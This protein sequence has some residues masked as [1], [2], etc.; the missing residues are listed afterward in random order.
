MLVA[1][2]YGWTAPG[3]VAADGCGCSMC[4][5]DQDGDTDQADFGH[6]QECFGG[7]DGGMTPECADADLNGNGAIEVGD[8]EAFTAC[9]GGADI[10]VASG[11]LDHLF[12]T[13]FMASNGGV[14]ADEDGEHPDWV[15]LHNPCRPAMNLNGYYLTDDPLDLT[16][17]RFPAVTLGKGKFLVVFASDKDRDDPTQPLH[18]NFKLSAESGYLALVAPDGQTIVHAYEPEYSEQLSDV[19]FGLTQSATQLIAQRADAKYRILVF[20]DGLGTSWTAPD[21]V[22][23]SWNNAKTGIG[24][25]SVPPYFDVTVYKANISVSNLAVAES[26]I[27]QPSQQAWVATEQTTTINYFN[28]DSEGHF[29]SNAT[30]PG[31]QIGSGVDHFVVLVTGTIVIPTPGEWSFGVNSDDGFG[32]TLTR[33]NQVYETSYPPPRGPS[34]TIAVFNLVEAGTYQVRLVYYEQGGGAGLEFFAAQG[35]YP[36]F[37]ANAYRLVGDSA[38]GGVAVGV[39]G[40]TIDTDLGALMKNRNASLRI[41]VPFQV[42]DPAAFNY[43]SLRMRYEDGFVAF[44]N[45]VEVARRNAPE[46]LAWN[47]TATSDRSLSDASEPEE[48]NLTSFVGHLRQGANVLAI[49]GLNDTAADGDF[50]ILPELVAGSNT[51]EQQYFANP[52]PGTYNV[53]GSIDFI[54]S[55]S[56]SVDHGFFESPFQLAMTTPTPGVE[57]RYTLDGS[58]PTETNGFVYTGPLTIDRTSVIRAGAFRPGFLSSDIVTRTYLF[59]ADVL[60]QSPN[61]ELPGPGWPANGAINGAQFN[62]GMDPSIL[63]DARYAGQIDDALLAIPT[64]SLVT[65]LANLFDP[66]IGIYV[67]PGGEGIAWERRTSVELLNPDGTEGF[68]VDGGLRIRGGYSR[69]TGNPKHAFRLFF[70]SEYGAGKLNYPLFGDEGADEFDK[71]DLATAQNYSW[72]FEYGDRNTFLRDMFSRDSQRDAGRP[73]TR[74]RYYHLYINGVYWGLYYTQERAEA[75]FAATYFGG[76]DEDYDVV[77]VEAGP[78][79]IYATDGDLDAWYRLWQ[80]VE[81]GVTNEAYQQAIGNNPDGTRNTAYEVLVD[82]D[83]L[84]DYM[85]NTFFVGDPDGPVAWGGDFPNNFYAIRNRNG[86]TGFRFFRHDAE[87]SMGAATGDVNENRTGPFI[88]GENFD[89]FN[90]YRIHL[91]FS[92]C[93]DY[94]TRFMDRA[95]QLLFNGG[96]FT[97][98]ACIDRVTARRDQ[99]DMAI[100]A[101]SARWGDS[102]GEP[103]RNK[104]D[105]WIPAVNW[106]LNNYLPNR[107]NAVAQQFAAKSLYAAPPVLSHP[108]GNVA[109]GT[110]IVL[111]YPPGGAG[112][113]YY[114]LDGSDPRLP[115]GA[116]SPQAMIYE[117][118]ANNETLLARSS[119]WLYLDNGSNQ[120]TA[121]Y[122]TGYPAT[123]WKTGQAPLGYDNPG[124]ITTVSFGPN[125]GQ[126]YATTYFRKTFNAPAG[127]TFTSLIMNLLRDDGAAVYLNGQLAA[128][129]IGLPASWDFSTYTG[130]GWVIGGADESTY[131]PY[132]LDAGLLHEG[133]N[134]IAVEVHQTSEGSSDLSFDMD[135]IG[136]WTTAS[137]PIMINQNVRL[138]TRIL[139]NGAWSALNQADYLVGP[140][141]LYINEIMASNATSLEDPDEPGEHPDWFELYNPNPF[142]VE[143][144][145]L[146]VTDNL[147]EPDKWQLR[148]GLTIKAGQF[149]VI[150][151]DDDGTQGSAHVGFKLSNDGEAVGLFDRDGITQ[152]DAVSFGAQGTDISIGR[153]PDGTGGWAI[154]SAPTPG[155]ANAQPQ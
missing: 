4:D 86:L 50:M 46:V 66:G 57:I 132:E 65:D 45:G 122:A 89:R 8:Y 15:E 102:K 135:L 90:P 137:N 98:Q 111:S 94:R 83:N 55:L 68:A 139:N 63:N 58:T 108:G 33:G 51:I 99:I 14:L 11:D 62:Y 88:A 82:V 41:R 151:A 48:F 76:T 69:S 16:K 34:D 110:E 67:N 105:T 18:A 148:Q 64:I 7:H 136:T 113:I 109:V 141:P 152:I 154:L 54:R 129:A 44:L 155:A 72:S 138:K 24:F 29:T 56:F 91:R 106:I 17:W 142:D 126:K 36:I 75:D 27:A 52:T 43:V 100:I 117:A 26:V 31:M 125:S 32:L 77:K 70:R 134:V 104:I 3:A 78:Y 103:P 133:Q 95:Y 80:L 39:L 28:T 112:T 143:L 1:L 47:S 79:T 127:K 131:F 130:S 124:I 53:G 5:F 9:A 107:A 149:L 87:H 73:Y 150:Y 97:P 59:I 21:F 35:N 30:F 60:T 128:P 120:G 12:I 101:E 146:Y 13:E 115:G 22:D 114:T 147:T 6:L 118:S 96:V 38:N 93:E 92:E 119:S 74:S 85:I 145:G 20:N 10:P 123:G 116:I 23:T 84:I 49:Q 121:W 19:S 71:V 2:F 153:Y 81:A 140:V 42:A 40:G 37:D 61:G 25:S 144:S